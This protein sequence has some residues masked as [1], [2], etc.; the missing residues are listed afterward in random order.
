MQRGF[1]KCQNS[2]LSWMSLVQGC[3]DQSSVCMLAF[4][5]CAGISRAGYLWRG[6]CVMAL[7]PCCSYLTLLSFHRTN[8][9]FLSLSQVTGQSF[10]STAGSPARVRGNEW[11]VAFAV[12]IIVSV[13]WNVAEVRPFWHQTGLHTRAQSDQEGFLKAV[14][15]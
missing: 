9:S 6:C 2:S 14:V 5:C 1:G 15:E 12:A 13:D 10:E 11:T 3:S 8:P 7:L 4:P